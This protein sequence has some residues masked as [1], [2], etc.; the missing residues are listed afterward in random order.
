MVWG[1]DKH[2]LD[3]VDFPA[4]SFTGCV[5]VDKSLNMSKT[6]FLHMQIDAKIDNHLSMRMM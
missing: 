6:Q 5:A 2:V 1:K 4:F 3:L